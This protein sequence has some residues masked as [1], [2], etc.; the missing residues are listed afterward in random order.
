[1]REGK[2]DQASR[3]IKS[4]IMTRVIYSVL[5][6]DIFEQECVFLKG[7]LQ[8]PRLKYHVKTIDIH[9]DLSNNAIYEHKCLENIKIYTNK[10]VSVTTINNSK[11]FLRMIWFLLLNDS[12]TIVLYLQ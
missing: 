11:T 6:I 12:P 9:P 1:M 4:R 5:S 3:F 7:M 2:S 10:L 8:S